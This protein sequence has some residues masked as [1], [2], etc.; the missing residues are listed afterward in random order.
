MLRA[1]WLLFLVGTTALAVW[2]ATSLVAWAG[3]PAELAS[4]GGVLLFPLLPW[5][6]EHRATEAWHA[7][8]RRARRLLP[9]KRALSGFS[10]FVL[11]SLALNL[12]LLGALTALWPRVAFA[13]LAARGDWF[14]DGRTGPTAQ[15]VRGV[16]VAAATGLEWLHR[17]AH[18]NPYR[19]PEDARAPVPDSVR[20]VTV[21][22][23]SGSGARWRR[24][25]GPPAQRQSPAGTDGDEPAPEA[26]QPEE[27]PPPLEGVEGAT[28]RVGRTG[29][30]WP[31]TVHPVVAGMTPADEPS[32]EA[33]ARFITAREPDPFRRVKALHDWVV[34]RLDYDQAALQAGR[35]PPQDA[36]AV[37]LSRRAVCEGYARLLV[38]LGQHA[39]V[40]V[41]YVTGEVREPEGALAT[42]GHAWNAVELEGAWYLV[43]ATWND[44]LVAGGGSHYR[45]DYL[46]IPPALAVLDHFPDEPRWQLLEQPLTRAEFL[47]QPLARPALAKEGLTLVTPSAL[48]VEVDERFVLELD[49]PTRAHVML[50]LDGA[51]CGISD[52]ARV[53]LECQVEGRGPRV[54]RVLANRS[55]LGTYT[56]VAGF[57][58]IR[59]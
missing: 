50:S 33:V 1:A 51:D 7:R 45:L 35:R 37:F 24:V 34:T 44:A 25:E 59:R 17:A 31:E 41:V 58:V 15:R 43:D 57:R 2:V 30:P 53:R 28:W 8:Q 55:R 4:A 21:T 46:F 38:A 16:L 40:R 20:P 26:P 19:R 42:E 52:D 36:E 54:A 3:G 47:R 48:A 9:A 18:D 27:P 32:L 23:P 13:A 5:W 49:N 29:W 56:W 11:R 39:G 12:A 22:T 10:R 14:L 6:W